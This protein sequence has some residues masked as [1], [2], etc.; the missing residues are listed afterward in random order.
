MRAED[1]FGLL[2]PVTFVVFLVT[3]R[4]FTRRARTPRWLG[5]VIQRPEAHG[6]HH[7]LGEHRRNYSDFPLWD[8]LTGTFVNPEVSGVAYRIAGM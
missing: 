7:E 2:I 3:E 1:V 8:M 4:M 6:L 5:Y